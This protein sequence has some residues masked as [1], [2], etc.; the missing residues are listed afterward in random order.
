MR[1]K[2]GAGGTEAQ[3]LFARWLRH[4]GWL[5][6][7]AGKRVKFQTSD[8]FGCLDAL[9][10][11]DGDGEDTIVWGAQVTTAEGRHASSSER[12]KKLEAVVWPDAWRISLVNHERVP[13]PADRKH[14]L[15]YWRVQDLALVVGGRSGARAWEKPRAVLFSRAAVEESALAPRRERE[16]MELEALRARVAAKNG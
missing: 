4:E 6:A 7:A 8:L 15:D 9:A 14:T 16:A 13:D 12:K 2:R 5:V 10:L 1:G 3:T 11:L